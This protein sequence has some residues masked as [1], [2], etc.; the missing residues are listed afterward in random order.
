MNYCKICHEVKNLVIAEGD[1]YCS[2]CLPKKN[3]NVMAT[4]NVSS[5]V[6]VDKEKVENQG[7]ELT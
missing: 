2:N 1:Y 4:P 3:E 7:M 5:S 6:L